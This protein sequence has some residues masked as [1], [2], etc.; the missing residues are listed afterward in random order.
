MRGC[1]D[2]TGL[3]RAVAPSLWVWVPWRRGAPEQGE[4]RAQ[5]LVVVGS[6]SDEL[7]KHHPD[8]FGLHIAHLGRLLAG[9]H[10]FLEEG[11]RVEVRDG[12]AGGQ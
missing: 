8:G 11:V 10:N 3:R 6:C 9:Y 1:R 5:R 12:G 7:L 4:L 2:A